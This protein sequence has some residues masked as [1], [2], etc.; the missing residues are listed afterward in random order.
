MLK[1]KKINN[2]LIKNT[3]SLSLYKNIININ[4]YKIFNLLYQKCFINN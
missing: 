4:L 2:N 3:L 1:F